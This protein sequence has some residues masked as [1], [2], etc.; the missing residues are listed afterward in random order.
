LYQRLRDERTLK[1]SWHRTY[2]VEWQY[3]AWWSHRNSTGPIYIY[4]RI[5]STSAALE[6]YRRPY[7]WFWQAS[8][9]PKQHFMSGKMVWM[10][11]LA[12]CRGSLGSLFSGMARKF[13]SCGAVKLDINLIRLILLLFISGVRH[14]SPLPG[15]SELE[16]HSV[17]WVWCPHER[18]LFW[19]ENQILKYLY[20]KRCLGFHLY[21]REWF[22]EQKVFL[23]GRLG[24][25]ESE[26]CVASLFSTLKNFQK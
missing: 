8:Q 21:F 7:G 26:V 1:D 10:H 20:C 16:F 11:A 17:L 13:C 18:V 23:W 6:E 15:T 9:C 14:I 25:G 19:W 12:L 3:W 22:C 2:Q 5:Q 4:I 24:F